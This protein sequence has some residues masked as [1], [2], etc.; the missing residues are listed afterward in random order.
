MVEWVVPNIGPKDRKRRLMWCEYWVRKLYDD[1]PEALALA[2]LAEY[3]RVRK[4]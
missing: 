4:A 1:A 3:D 2:L